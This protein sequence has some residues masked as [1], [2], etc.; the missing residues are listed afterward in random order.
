MLY[1]RLRA[2]QYSFARPALPTAGGPQSGEGVADD[3]AVKTEPGSGTGV[4]GNEDEGLRDVVDLLELAAVGER[5]GGVRRDWQTRLNLGESIV[6][7]GDT[8]RNSGR[9]DVRGLVP[10]FDPQMLERSNLGNCNELMV[11]AVTLNEAHLEVDGA[12]RRHNGKSIDFQTFRRICCTIFVGVANET[13]RIFRQAKGDPVVQAGRERIEYVL[14]AAIRGGRTGKLEVYDI[15]SRVEQAVERDRAV[16]RAAQ[17]QISYRR[18][19]SVE[20]RRRGSHEA[21]R[22]LPITPIAWTSPRVLTRRS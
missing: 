21:C 14:T 6:T 22:S 1:K 7:D 9:V 2:D 20:D 19:A 5:E 16:C 18:I 8:D 13:H 4:N 10:V 12:M 17:A 11:S 3:Q 15:L